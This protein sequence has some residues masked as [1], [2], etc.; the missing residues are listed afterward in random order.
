MKST[1]RRLA[2][3]LQRARALGGGRVALLA[4]LSLA[5]AS[6]LAL[7]DRSASAAC[8]EDAARKI[9]EAGKSYYDT[10]YYEDALRSFKRAHDLCPKAEL[11]LNIGATQERLGDLAAAIA[12]YEQ[13]TVDAPGADDRDSTLARIRNLKQRMASPS[14]STSAP[15]GTSSAPAPSA[16]AP[17]AS[18]PAPAGGEGPDGPVQQGSSRLPAYVSFGV[19]GAAAIGA[20]ATGLVANG[21]Y[22]DAES[23]CSPRCNDDDVKGIKTMALVST[24]LTGVAV[25]GAGVGV[26][27]LLL[28]GRDE[29]AASGPRSPAGGAGLTPLRWRGLSGGV[30]PQSGKLEASWTFLFALIAARCGRSSARSAPRRS[31]AAR[32]CSTPTSSRQTTARLPEA[33]A[34]PRVFPRGKGASRAGAPEPAGSRRRAARA[35]A[36]RAPGPRVARREKAEQRERPEQRERLGLPE[37]RATQVRR[38]RRGPRARRPAR[39]SSSARTATPARSTSASTWARRARAR[40]APAQA[41]RSWARASGRP[42]QALGSSRRSPRRSSTPPTASGSP[43]SS[44]WARRSG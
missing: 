5:A 34:G 11:L 37:L 23:S 40:P 4:A 31:A 36:T 12:A 8:A 9:F 35:R 1:P 30:G 32:C 6:G 16:A 13:Y 39:A 42:G 21:R 28:G 38:V 17:S 19:A 7:T 3:R 14:G 27:L 25:A 41:T 22:S 26:V 15:A 43:C 20:V 18:G 29:S 33:R 44:R 2:R 10:G 24:V